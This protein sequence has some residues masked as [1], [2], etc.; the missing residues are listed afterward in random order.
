MTACMFLK[1]HADCRVGNCW[2]VG[3]RLEEAG[4]RWEK[5]NKVGH[6]YP[7]VPQRGCAWTQWEQAA[8]AGRSGRSQ[9]AFHVRANSGRRAACEPEREKER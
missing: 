7:D 5:G 1:D 4:D 2:G 8:E 6:G 9:D 3:G